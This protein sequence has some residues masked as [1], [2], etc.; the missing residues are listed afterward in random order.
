MAQISSIEQY[1][2]TL[3]FGELGYTPAAIR[4]LGGGASQF[5]ISTGNPAIAGYQVDAGEF[6]GDEWRMLP[7]FNVRHWAPL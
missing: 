6:V 5:S 2:R 1:R 7:N 3:A 4:M